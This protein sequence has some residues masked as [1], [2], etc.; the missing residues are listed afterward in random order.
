[1]H[2]IEFQIPATELMYLSYVSKFYQTVDCGLL[3]CD[4]ALFLGGYQRFT[5]IYR[6]EVGI[7]FFRDFGNQ[8]PTSWHG[9][10]STEYC[11]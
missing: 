3:S 6:A 4:A 11:S 5:R 10:K 8:S 1:M 7:I 9:V 2:F